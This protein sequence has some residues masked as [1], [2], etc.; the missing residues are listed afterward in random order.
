MLVCNYLGQSA[1]RRKINII[2]IVA[3]Y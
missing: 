2:L 1:N 3:W